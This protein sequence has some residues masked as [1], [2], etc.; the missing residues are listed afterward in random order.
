MINSGRFS[1]DG[2][3]TSLPDL[4]GHA[5]GITRDGLLSKGSTASILDKK[6]E[7]DGHARM[8]NKDNVRRA[9]KLMR[10]VEIPPIRTEHD[11]STRK[12]FGEVSNIPL[13]KISDI[14]KSA[15]VSL[16]ERKMRV[17]F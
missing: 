3:V 13:Q 11:Y 8:D 16:H 12:M 9:L 1:I 7:G 17:S 2:R 5:V 4:Q 14:E 6:L 15:H 10:R